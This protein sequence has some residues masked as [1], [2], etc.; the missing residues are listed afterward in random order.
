[1]QCVVCPLYHEMNSENGMSVSCDIF[2]D[3]WD[4]RF[5]Y[6]RYKQIWGC[7]I[8]KTYIKKV[9]KERDA[10]YERMAKIEA[11]QERNFV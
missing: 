1:M 11:E 2:G 4:S 7:Y 5:M 9:E 3:S 8:D 6:K 10:Y